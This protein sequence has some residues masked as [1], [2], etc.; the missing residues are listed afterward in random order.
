MIGAPE[1]CRTRRL[2]SDI[3]CVHFHKLSEKRNWGIKDADPLAIQPFNV[4]FSY[5]DAVRFPLRRLGHMVPS[6]VG[7]VGAGLYQ[8]HFVVP[9]VPPDISRCSGRSGNLKVLVSG[10]NSAGQAEICVQ[11]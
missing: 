5:I 8:V 2:G 3:C 9:S 1:I 11:P 4:N 10:P 7:M 6:Y